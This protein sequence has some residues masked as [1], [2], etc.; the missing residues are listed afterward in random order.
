MD[1]KPVL[2]LLNRMY[3]RYLI[4]FFLLLCTLSSFAQKKTESFQIPLPKEKVSSSLYDSIRLMDI[5]KDTTDFGIVQKG[6]FNRQAK[7]VADIPLAVQLSDVLNALKDSSAHNGELLLL[8]RQCSFAEIMKTTSEKGY[9]HFRAILFSHENGW[10]KKIA[11][12]DTVV[13]V[14]SSIDVTKRMY[15]LGCK[16]I[17]DFIA[18]HLTQQPKEELTLSATQLPSIDSIEK[19]K[20]PLYAGSTYADG[21]YYNFRSF[22]NQQPDETTIS[23][24]F[25]KDGQLRRI[26]LIGKDGQKEKVKSKSAYA[27]VYHG[28]PYICTKYGYYP[29]EKRE[30]DFYFTGKASD[31]TSGDLVTAEIFFG[32]MG[33]LLAQSAT[34][35][36]EMKLDHL[37]GGFIRIKEIIP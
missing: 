19:S 35:V 37:S 1:Y 13:M 27:V 14:K 33:G 21:I 18:H 5:R 26:Y 12:I 15:R 9:F 30:N 32:I 4:I 31:Y 6:V 17:T 7:V 20:L 3:K 23:V 36:F 8:L 22:A 34:S 11:A 24:S 28:K 25:N 16:T 29:L 10:Y 2:R